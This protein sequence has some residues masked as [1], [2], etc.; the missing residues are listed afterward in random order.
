[1]NNV[2][3]WL[4]TGTPAN[5]R[6]TAEIADGWLPLGYVPGKKLDHFMPWLEEGF[7][8]AGGGKSL[9]DIEIQ[10]GAT[11]RITDDVQGALDAMKPGTALYIGGMGHR[12]KNFHNDNMVRRGYADA[13]QRIQS[14]SSPDAR[15]KPLPPS[16][17]SSS[18]RPPSSAPSS[19]SASATSS[20]PTT[21]SPASP[22]TPPSPRPWSSWPSSPS[23]NPS[24]H[25][26]RSAP[27]PP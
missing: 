24:R 17:T 9:R 10:V 26:R 22:S 16:P 11:V 2:P 19:A 13:A 3:I 27:H 7:R 20:G 23:S 5:T 8:R 12:T 6:L 15:R 18:T 21:P 25:R 14:S 4:G 1:M